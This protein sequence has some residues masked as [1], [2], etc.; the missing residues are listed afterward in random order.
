[1][2]YCIGD[3]SFVTINWKVTACTCSTVRWLP[4][5]FFPSPQI[6]VCRRLWLSL[7]G[8]SGIL[9]SEKNNNVPCLVKVGWLST[10]FP[11]PLC[12]VGV[13]SIEQVGFNG[14]GPTLAA[15]TAPRLKPLTLRSA[16]Q[17][18]KDTWKK[19]SWG[20]CL[21]EHPC[22]IGGR[23]GGRHGNGNL[24]RTRPF[25]WNLG[26]GRGNVTLLVGKQPHTVS[27]SDEQ[28]MQNLYRGMSL[29]HPIESTFWTRSQIWRDHVQVFNQ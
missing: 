2:P 23:S 13:D 27:T 9:R 24:R 4:S 15:L 20:R 17:H 19:A 5:V 28:N 10:T 7:S 18:L 25:Q 1:M 22:K 16:A 21:E 14:Y 11:P 3:Y 6:C 29:I 12:G 8:F 26:L